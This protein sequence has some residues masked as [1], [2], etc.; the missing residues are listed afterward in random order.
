MV[1]CLISSI[2]WTDSGETCFNPL[3]LVQNTVAWQVGDRVQLFARQSDNVV[4][5]SDVTHWGHT[6]TPPHPVYKW[7]FYPQAFYELMV[8]NGNDSAVFY[9]GNKENS[10]MRS[11]TKRAVSALQWGRWLPGLRGCGA[12]FLLRDLPLFNLHPVT[13]T[14]V[15]GQIN[16]LPSQVL[17]CC[18]LVNV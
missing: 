1:P 2:H 3:S 12:G 18:L 13:L 8:I 5:L 4:R 7:L 11:R 9:W 16:H 14:T 10:Q 6:L 15:Q 17:T